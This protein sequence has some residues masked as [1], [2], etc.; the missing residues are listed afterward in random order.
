MND[1]NLMQLMQFRNNIR[2]THTTYTMAL[3]TSTHLQY[4]RIPY[5]ANLGLV[6]LMMGANA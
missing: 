6:L 2:T 5:A 1:T 3:H 4:L